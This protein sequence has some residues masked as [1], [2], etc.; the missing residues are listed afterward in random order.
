[1]SNPNSPKVNVEKKD[2]DKIKLYQT[3]DKSSVE[4]TKELNFRLDVV[5]NVFSSPD[6]HYFITKYGSQE[7]KDKLKNAEIVS[8]A[9]SGYYKAIISRKQE[10]NENL[11]G[12]Q[13]YLLEQVRF[14]RKS[15]AF[16]E[17]RKRELEDGISGLEKNLHIGIQALEEAEGIEENRGIKLLK[18][19]NEDERNES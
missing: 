12:I 3:N 4:A 19:Q 9:S 17:M 15:V 2:F 13:N 8:P 7:Q 16:L 6:F 14:L 11:K 10:T 1:M 18:K 5:N